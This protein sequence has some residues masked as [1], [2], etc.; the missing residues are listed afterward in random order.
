MVGSGP[1]QASLEALSKQL[2]IE[3]TVTFWG[4]RDNVADY[5]APTQAFI[6]SS[7]TEGLP[8]AALE[9]MAA[10]LPVITTDI[11][12]TPEI[13]RRFGNGLIAPPRNPE[14]L[15]AAIVALATS[16]EQTQSM[17]IASRNAYQSH[18]T[19]QTMN[20]AYLKLYR[21]EA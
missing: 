9:A 21:G 12:G 3:S 4:M 19:N 14:A 17:G 13:V 16:P 11:G 1:L 10:G 2:Q 7:I 6:L 15:A 20:E 5:L 8:I 18:F